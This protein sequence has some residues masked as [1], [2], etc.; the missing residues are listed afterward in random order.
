MIENLKFEYLNA[1]QIRISKLQAQNVLNLVFDAW[2]LF[3]ISC[4][5]F[6]I[7]TLRAKP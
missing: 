4:F 7:F 1:N 5:G 3:R 6:R 2:Y